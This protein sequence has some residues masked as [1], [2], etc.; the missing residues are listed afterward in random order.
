MK[1]GQKLLF[2]FGLLVV[3]FVGLVVYN[4]L[5]LQVIQEKKDLFADRAAD[6]VLITEIQALGPE[7]YQII[8]DAIINRDQDETMKNWA[9]KK[10]EAVSDLKTL[11]EIVDSDEEKTLEADVELYFAQIVSIVEDKLFPMIFSGK[12]NMDDV[13]VLDDKIDNL[14][15]EFKEPLDKIEASLNQE[16]AD[17][18][19]AIGETI[20]SIITISV[21]IAVV[22]ILISVIVAMVITRSIT[23]P[24]N[25]SVGVLERVARGD[26]TV[27]IDPKYL[28]SKDEIGGMLVGMN[29]MIQDLNKIAT[30]IVTGSENIASATLQVSQS[31]QDLSQRTTEQAS[32]VEEI[33]SSIEEMTATIRQNADNASQTEKIAG[34]SSTDANESGSI[35]KKTVTAMNEIAEK[36]SIVQ[37]I[38]RQT[39]LLSLNASIEAARAGEH[40]KGFAVVASG[41]QKLA[42]RSQISA[43]EIGKLAKTSVEI[44]VLAGEMLTRLVPDIQK[45]AELVSEINAASGEQSSGVQ[46]I[47]NAIQQLNSVV[48]QNASSA[49]ELASTAEEVT[50]QS[51]ALKETMQFFKLDD[52]EQVRRPVTHI[53]HVGP[54]P[55]PKPTQTKVALHP[56]Q[57]PKGFEYDMKN[58]EDADDENYVR[59]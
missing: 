51:Q 44:A 37:E 47:N 7:M 10:S 59:F 17:D 26:L 41:V 32:S 15:A 58:P 38:A 45:T 20:T 18:Q 54:K 11:K 56:N 21:I 50:A 29:A 53:P 9:A 19:K 27:K 33:S 57:N 42:E 46:Q 5:Q 24:V 2:G 6:A 52:T 14:V 48:Q 35:V 30:D 34:K 55:L 13:R 28:S 49:E 8:G 31:S 25:Y 36:I 22:I 12:D 16:L 43:T 1:I 23:K 40:G 3:L 39:N 4:Y